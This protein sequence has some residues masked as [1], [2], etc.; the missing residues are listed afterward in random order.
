[1]KNTRKLV[2]AES[3]MVPQRLFLVDLLVFGKTTS[4]PLGLKKK[5]L[6]SLL[7]EGKMCCP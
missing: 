1:L 4:F 6:S 5:I 7:S 2:K 3:E